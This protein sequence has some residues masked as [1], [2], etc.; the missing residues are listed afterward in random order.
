MQAAGDTGN[1]AHRVAHADP[2]KKRLLPEKAG[3]AL[4]HLPQ[5]G[6]GQ[7][8]PVSSPGRTQLQPLRPHLRREDGLLGGKRVGEHV[9][10]ASAAQRLPLVRWLPLPKQKPCWAC[11]R[12]V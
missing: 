2:S 4:Q 6:A 5:A 3:E 1:G 12:R 9:V 11:G 8:E 7:R 10:S